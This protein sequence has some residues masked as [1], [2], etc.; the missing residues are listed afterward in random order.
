M[1]NS[2]ENNIPAWSVSA[3]VVQV[4]VSLLGVFLNIMLLYAHKRDPCK[5]LQSSSSPFIVNI[6]VN[7][8][9]VLCSLLANQFLY[10]SFNQRSKLAEQLLGF[11]HIALTFLETVSVT[12]IFS[13]S[14]ERFFS[15]AFPL[16]HRVKITTRITRYWLAAVWLFHLTCE[17]LMLALTLYYKRSIYGIFSRLSLMWLTFLLTQI[18][19][20][21]SYVSLRK[22]RRELHKRQNS[23]EDNIRMMKIRLERERNFLITIAIV[24]SILALTLLPALTLMVVMML[25][26]SIQDWSVTNMSK[27]PTVVWGVTMI[28]FNFSVNGLV[29]LWRMKKYRITFKKLYCKCL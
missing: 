28:T 23:S 6:A 4:T 12:S 26:G 11:L 5:L 16:W 13:L 3:M 19:Y 27:E 8:F 24:C 17:G 7:D 2:T 1:N 21:A 29:Y 15:V 18:M 22:Q 20:L 9:L 25:L 14:V 10:F